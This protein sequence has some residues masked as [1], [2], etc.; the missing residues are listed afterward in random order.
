MCGF[1]GQLAVGVVW[2][3]TFFLV[4]IAPLPWLLFAYARG[5]VLST[6]P[7]LT[8]PERL[9]CTATCPIPFM[10]NVYWFWLITRK[11][12]RMAAGSSKPPKGRAKAE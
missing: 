10:L 4:R 11:A 1:V 3:L 12:Y 9:F 8:L 5:I 6:D 7:A 2:L